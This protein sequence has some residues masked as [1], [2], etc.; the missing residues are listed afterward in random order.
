RFRLPIE[1]VAA[2]SS[3]VLFASGEFVVHF[4]YDPRYSQ[5]GLMVQLLAIGLAIYPF[6]LIRSA[7]T[8][9]GDTHVVAGVSVLQAAS[10]ILCLV[11]GFVIAGPF[12]A[13][14]GVAVHRVIPSLMILALAGQRY[15]IDLRQEF[16]IVPAFGAGVVAGKVAVAMMAALGVVDIAQLW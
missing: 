6:H 13:V 11:A 12:G 8:V 14:M 5:A 10:L 7:F 3:G 1:L 2:A 9:V 15:W 4:L 16:R